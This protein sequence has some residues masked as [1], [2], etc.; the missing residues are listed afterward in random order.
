MARVSRVELSGL[1][2]ERGIDPNVRPGLA[3]LTPIVGGEALQ[4]P[5]IWG[6]S[7]RLRLAVRP[8]HVVEVFGQ[9]HA[10][11]MNGVVAIESFVLESLKRG[12]H[13]LFAEGDLVLNDDV[14][15]GMHLS[16]GQRYT[17]ATVV[18]GDHVDAVRF[19]NPQPFS[20]DRFEVW[21]VFRHHAPLLCWV[22]D[23]RP[24]WP[25]DT[26]LNRVTPPA[27]VVLQHPTEALAALNGA[28]GAYRRGLRMDQVVVEALVIPLVVIVRNE[29][30]DA[31]PQRALADQNHALEARLL[32]RADEA[33]GVGIQ[34]R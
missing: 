25:G 3:R 20:G 33:L 34:I 30:T 7:V 32:D 24:W 15:R 4:S 2:E 29:L 9:D 5:E 12:D 27:V 28:V 8:E 6:M 16:V 31:P 17:M 19:G 13:D 21:V 26:C 10:D 14:N 22:F 18:V 11:R 1:S 23:H